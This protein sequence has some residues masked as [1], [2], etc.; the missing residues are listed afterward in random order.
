MTFYAYKR[1]PNDT[2]RHTYTYTF[3]ERFS[4]SFFYIYIFREFQ[5]WNSLTVTGTLDD[6]TMEL[7]NRPRCGLPDPKIPMGEVKPFVLGI[8]VK[9]LSSY[10][11]SVQSFSYYYQCPET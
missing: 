3:I 5:R 1:L 4:S 10:P 2:L 11:Y 8:F 9:S 7:M 6:A